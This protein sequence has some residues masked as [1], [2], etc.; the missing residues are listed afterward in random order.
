MVSI[1]QYKACL[2]AKGFDQSLGFDYFETF[3]PI[4]KPTTIRVVLNLALSK[5]W[6]IWQLN[7]H[8]AILNGDLAKQVFMTQP[9]GFVDTSKPNYVCKLTKALYGLKQ[10][11][12]MW[13]TKLS[14]A[15]IQWGFCDSKAD[16]SMFIYQKHS[17][18][19]AVLVYVYDIIVTESSDSLI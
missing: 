6:S 8:N 13:F 1:D 5:A 9:E 10:A 2:V 16:T 18:M 3:S 17:H 4:V 11:I 14:T 19:L 15:H 12:V 7:V